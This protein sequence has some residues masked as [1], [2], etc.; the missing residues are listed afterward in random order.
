MAE[1]KDDTSKNSNSDPKY[2]ARRRKNREA[3]LKHR[4]KKT[5]E[6]EERQSRHNRLVNENS[7][8]EGQVQELKNCRKLLQEIL[9]EQL[10][11]RGQRL[12]AEQ[13]ELIKDVDDD[14]SCSS[15][16]DDSN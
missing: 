12:T 4:L 8:L 11:R 7:K 13:L 9:I 2:L 14:F 10:E 5:L 3:V 16:S 1:L 6:D 15:S